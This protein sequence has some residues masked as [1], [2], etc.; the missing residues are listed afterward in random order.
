MNGFSSYAGRMWFTGHSRSVLV[1][2][3]TVMVACAPVGAADAP[4]ARAPVQVELNDAPVAVSSS[5]LV[6]ASADDGSPSPVPVSTAD[7]SWGAPD[8][9]VTLVEFSDF[10]C[11]FCGRVEPTL[12]ALRARYGPAQLR[13]VWKHEPLPFHQFARRA[14]E[15]AQAVFVAGGSRAFWAFHDRA[16]ANQGTLD[17]AHF[18]QWAHDS[19]VPDSVFRA[20]LGG[21]PGAKVDVDLALASKLG[22]TGTPTSFI[23]G[24]LVSGAQPLEKFTE[25]VDAEL[26]AAK[27]LIASGAPPR[28]VYA[29]RSQKNFQAPSAPAASKSAEE[30]APDTTV[31]QVPVLADD[32]VRGPNDALVTIVE[33][34]DFQCPF[35]Q[36]V[37]ETLHSLQSAY[38]GL[39]RLV[40]KNNPLPFHPRA[41]PAALLAQLVY[42]KKGNAAF[43]TAH[44][45]LFAS[46]PKLEEADFTRIAQQVGLSFPTLRSKVE[47]APA[48]PAID[49][50]SSL[51]DDLKARGTPTFFIN[52]VML[53]G[54]QPLDA[55]KARVDAALA[56]A[57]ARVAK[58]VA[59][60][61][62][63]AELMKDA[64]GPVPP[65]QKQV[66]APRA[67]APTHGPANAAIVVQEFADFQ[68]PFCKRVEPTL[69]ELS[70]TYP[71]LKI[72]FRHLPLPFHQHAELAA[73]AAEEVLAQR[74]NAA[75]WSY[76]DALYEAQ[77]DP[78]GLERANLIKLA[79]PLGVDRARL[80]QALDSSKHKAQ[81]DAD[82]KA[83]N[84]AG[85]NG[86]PAF[87]INGYF[88]SGAQSLVA[89]KK[90][91][92]FAQQPRKP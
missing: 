37:E 13:I 70:K 44:D 79:L 21:N 73:E 74:G 23:N 36:R 24:A 9:P 83:A 75:F 92:R 49:G 12:A 61:R 53:A 52:G 27:Q 39:T 41:L 78:D 90:A 43:W 26:A 16:F 55:F 10:Q 85:I 45:A 76:H 18:A 62:V 86:T 32:P 11:P 40:W 57:R 65:E 50:A 58:G 1:W 51:A 2:L 59:P 7:P 71:S 38:P 72:V 88:V 87:V 63:Y 20:E 46:Q 56:D 19:G 81:I 67:G 80:E 14:H 68:C 25:L 4:L 91:V 89:F 3:S 42:Q 48:T 30:E 54:A 6:A 29:L 5:D 22:A 47:G 17:A 84:D 77:S 34:S 82:A 31:W 28:T 33:F 66:G 69:A 64:K 60:A 8:A 15:A 35:C